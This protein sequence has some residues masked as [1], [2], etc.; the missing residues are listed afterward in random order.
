MFLVANLVAYYAM[1]ERAARFGMTA[2]SLEKNDMVIDG[3]LK[4]LEICKRAGVPVA[5]GSDL[6]GDLHVDQSREFILRS[7]VVSPIEIIR[8]ATTIAAQVLRQ[9]GKL[10]TLAPGAFAD[11][12]V[13]DGDPLKNLT[14][15][16]GQG[17][18]LSAI[19]KGGKFHKNR[20]N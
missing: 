4:S 11:I 3:G 15:L 16:E 8:S 14:L 12:I 19:M 18:H 7:E 13:V 20:L 2:E 5:Y 1:K 6:L 9:E 17:Q 10:G